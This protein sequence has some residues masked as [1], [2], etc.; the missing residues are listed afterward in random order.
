MKTKAKGWG[1][2]YQQH[3]RRGEDHG[4]AAHAADIWQ[5]KNQPEVYARMHQ[6]SDVKEKKMNPFFRGAIVERDHFP[7]WKF[8]VVFVIDD[9]ALIHSISPKRD[10]T[11]HVALLTEL[12]LVEEPVVEEPRG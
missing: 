8:K 2:I 12:H 3:L 6:K 11:V 5:K 7:T 4:F 9:M 10:D 1:D